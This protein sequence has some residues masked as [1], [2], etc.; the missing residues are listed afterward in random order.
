MGFGAANIQAQKERMMIILEK[1]G[2]CEKGDSKSW[3]S[4]MR[5]KNKLVR[6]VMV[7][8]EIEG[9]AMCQLKQRNQ[10]G[11]SKGQQHDSRKKL[12]RYSI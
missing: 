5:M 9:L 2:H 12:L 6:D 1:E 4:W 8:V 10:V 7:W 11:G 3:K